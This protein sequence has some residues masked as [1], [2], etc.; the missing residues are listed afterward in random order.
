MA[1]KK[2]EKQAMNKKRSPSNFL[3]LYGWDLLLGFIATFYVFLV[4]YTKV[5]ESFNVQYDHLEFPGVVPR[6]FI[7]A[8]LISI[9]ASP[10]M[11]TMYLLNLPKL[12][13]LF[14]GKR[15]EENLM[16]KVLV[17]ADTLFR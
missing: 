10:V 2:E 14:A 3:Q 8:L 16:L 12:Y 7:G 17:L 13:S 15:M 1:T 6:T 11:L 5:E 4:P 9:L